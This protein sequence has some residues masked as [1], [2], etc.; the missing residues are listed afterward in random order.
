MANRRRLTVTALGALTVVVGGVAVVDRLLPRTT[1]TQLAVED[2]HER[3]ER[4][5]RSLTTTTPI[6]TASPAP[7]ASPVPAGSPLPSAAP[8]PAGAS[9]TASSVVPTSSPAPAVP[10]VEPGVYVYATTGGDE[11]DALGGAHHDYPSTTTITVTPTAC[12]VLQRWDI[13][14]ERWQEWQRCSDGRGVSEGGRTNSD[15]FFDRAQTD[16]YL[17]TGEA[18]PRNAPAGAT[19][20][21]TCT[22]GDR[23]DV[24]NGMVVGTETL[25]VGD[26]SVETMHVRVTITTDRPTDSQVTDTWYLAG[27]DLVIAQTA[28]NS[29]SNDTIVGVV[30]YTEHY[31]IHLTSLTPIT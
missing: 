19:W 18:R 20:T 17:C 21:T 28:A 11:I 8:T 29:T 14:V 7:A 31:E 25:T 13:L 22:Q 4:Y 15:E 12:G 23:S 10:L 30:G 1:S 6:P 24:Y 2:A 27:G 5:Q 3:Y 16:T 26:S 9:P